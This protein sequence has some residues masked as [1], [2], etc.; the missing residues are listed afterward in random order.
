MTIQSACLSEFVGKHPKTFNEITKGFR[1]FPKN[2]FGSGSSG[3]SSVDWSKQRRSSKFRLDRI[4]VLQIVF[5]GI[6][7]YRRIRIKKRFAILDEAVADSFFP[8]PLNPVSHMRFK[9]CVRF[10]NHVNIRVN[11]RQYLRQIIPYH[12]HH[13]DE[14]SCSASLKIICT[15][16]DADQMAVAPL[17]ESVRTLH[18]ADG[19][20]CSCDG[21]DARKKRLPIFGDFIRTGRVVDPQ[22]YAEAN[23]D[24]DNDRSHKKKV[25]ELHH[26]LS[27]TAMNT[28]VPPGVLGLSGVRA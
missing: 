27:F 16:S 24:G 9:L 21:Q 1:H 11:R 23:A 2:R 13:I 5:D 12:F 8:K 14:G 18:L 25:I 10:A 6:V 26:R 17:L 3:Q 4:K 28:R 20:H 7:D 15:Q 22:P 19:E